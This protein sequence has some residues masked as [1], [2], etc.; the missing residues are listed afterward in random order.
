MSEPANETSFLR[1]G[2]FRLDPANARLTRE[3]QVLEV[4]PKDLDV[5]CY[6]ARRPGRLVTKDELLDAVWKQ[7][8][9]SE[10]VLKNVI[11]RL[12][13]LLGDEPKQPRYIETAQR[14]GYRFIAE[15]REAA[16]VAQPLQQI[17]DLPASLIGR[18]GAMSW[19]QQRLDAATAGRTQLAWISGEA[20]IGKSSLIEGFTR[21]AGQAEQAWVLTGQCIEHKG[22][23]EPYLPLLEA[24]SGLCK[25]RPEAGLV[26]LMR[27]VAPT[28]LVQLPWFVTAED[29]LLLQAEVAGATRERMLREFGEL[30]DR[31]TVDRPLIIVVEDLH[32]SDAA[33]V[34]L[35][36]F[37][38]RRQGSARALVLGSLR[39]AELPAA[40]H[41]L[42]ALRQQGP[43]D[44][45]EL[46]P[47]ST[48]DTAAYL[49]RHAPGTPWSAA[50]VEA[51]HEHTGGL[52]LFTAAVAAELSPDGAA[53]LQQLRQVPRSIVGLIEQQHGRLPEQSQRWLEA[54]SVA[55]V[56]FAHLPLA[57]ALGVDPDSLQQTF[58]ALVR[59]GACLRES[60][61]TALPD[62]RLAARY[63]FRHALYRHVL[64]DLAGATR[65]V[66]MHRRLAAALQQIYATQPQ[67]IAAELAV[68]HEKGQEPAL[69]VRQL[70][71][72]AHR[73]L[74]RFAAP[75]AATIA[76]H[77]LSLLGQ[78]EDR[79]AVRD[80]EIELN[81]ELGVAMTVLQGIGSPESGRAFAA[82]ADLMDDLHPAPAR[83]A[84]LHGI[85]WTML[86]R[87]KFGRAQGMAAQV[88][89]LAKQR[90]DAQLSFAAH[91]AMGITL[92]HTGDMA[93][94]QQHLTQAL[95][96]RPAL[97]EVLPDAMF[98]FEPGVQ[99]MSYQ[100]M[101]L[102][103]LGQ[104]SEAQTQLH[105][106]LFRAERL[107]HPMT[108]LIAH[109]FSALNAC[110]AQHFEQARAL[111]GRALERARQHGIARGAGALMW[112]N[113]RAM[114][115]LGEVD[116]G[117]D[118]MRQGQAAQLKNGQ[119]YG[120]TR[121]H[122]YY[123][124]TCIDAGRKDEALACLT[125]GLQL[126]EQTGEH[127]STSALHRLRGRLLH[128]AGQ[129]EA[130]AAAYQQ[131]HALA[132]D[133]GA[134]YLAIGAAASA[135]DLPGRNGTAAREAL[136][137]L[138][139]QWRDPL[140]PPFVTQARGLT[141][142]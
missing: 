41:P 104:P 16:L 19:L 25:T 69:A 62:G 135:A 28:W 78:I 38:A 91:S 1:F 22:T 116:A 71:I 55:G 138:L 111:T 26:A 118:L 61:T 67:T 63:V 11:S 130:A 81:V 134:L 5:L 60:G 56:E 140:D 126:A 117:L 114:A 31:L 82:A 128:E 8:F 83:I 109:V 107:G 129:V 39:P 90:N 124:Q 48:A 44:E 95:Q 36:G 113:G 14:R 15:V 34:Q 121:W 70:A 9:I 2:P 132:L 4:W 32:W 99:L 123:G 46:A 30:L 84:A 105:E 86:A 127:A 72:A 136:A 115:A 80:T 87:G 21:H 29:R 97:D 65:R 131:A 51:L 33:T 96:H 37:L 52:P 3:E 141:L 50:S 79:A 103:C 47:F 24:I 73:A 42:K 102:W 139:A 89:A 64:Y 40:E 92:A 49:S 112:L 57:E 45:L 27:Q 137:P 93:N 68:H 88:M 94:A 10:S 59:A 20:G 119:A 74:R 35:L 77:G 100:S 101:T 98:S 53:P 120:L 17:R 18:A 76:R 125:E 13:A 110:E 54:A 23:V 6:L 12:R 85:W 58:D 133:Q 122:E 142:R 108:L 106:A 75:E 66:L 43:G 7:R